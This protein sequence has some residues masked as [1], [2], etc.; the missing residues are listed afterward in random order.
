MTEPVEI[1]KL[2][3]TFTISQTF[4]RCSD[5]RASLAFYR[6][7]LGLTVTLG[8]AEMDQANAPPTASAAVGAPLVLY[9]DQS[10]GDPYAHRITLATADLDAAY[11]YLEAGGIEVIQE[12]MQRPNDVHDCAFLDPSGNIVHIEQ[13]PAA[14]QE[15]RDR[16][17]RIAHALA[18]LTQPEADGWI[19]TTSR[20][21]QRAAQAHM[22]PLSL[23]WINECVVIAVPEM[24][25]TARNLRE[26]PTARIGAGTTRDVVMLDAVVA[27]RLSAEQDDALRSAYRARAGWDPGREHGYEF[28]VLTP[29]RVQAW[30]ERNEIPGRDLMIDGQWLA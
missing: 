30:R 25:K 28:L 16:G 13:I 26:C 6:D 2:A 15:P 3:P 10:S 29:T 5:L 11:A 9:A 27:R 7:T 4:V 22:V 24:S 18:I 20:L 1:P 8:C 23:A 12:P 17:A 19:A 14:L 21:T